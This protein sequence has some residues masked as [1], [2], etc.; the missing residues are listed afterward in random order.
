MNNAL[1]VTFRIS[2]RR[3]RAASQQADLPAYS[4][5]KSLNRPGQ[6]WSHWQGLQVIQHRNLN[7]LKPSFR[8]CAL[9]NTSAL[10]SGFGKAPFS[11]SVSRPERTAPNSYAKTN[12]QNKQGNQKSTKADHPSS[13]RNDLSKPAPSASSNDSLYG[14]KKYPELR[15]KSLPQSSIK[16]IFGPTV[17]EKLGNDILRKLQSQRATGTLDD[18]ARMPKID[19]RL[20]AEGLM[21]LRSKYPFDED[22]AIMKR[23]EL[24]DLQT[25]AQ[26]IASAERLGLY[27][28]NANVQQIQNTEGRGI[29]GHSVLD[30]MHKH[31]EEVAAK[32]KGEAEKKEAQD[33]AEEIRNISQD[34]KNLQSPAGRAVLAR[35]T[36]SAEWVKRYKERAKVS[37]LTEPEKL[38]PFVRLWPSAIFTLIVIGASILFA[39]N[40]IP[41]PRQARLF[42]DTPPAAATVQTLIFINI[43][44][45]MMWKTPPLWRFMNRYCLLI[46]AFPKWESIL[47]NVFSHQVFSHLAVNMLGL[48]FAGTLRELVPYYHTQSLFL[49]TY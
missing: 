41:P 37:D 31:F 13:S 5:L 40:Y 23:I 35:R 43:A 28:P 15:F 19:P 4:P 25:D 24:E 44:A 2:C 6:I 8:S 17:P 22:A 38:H 18:V 20:E 45:F 27:Q 29:Y 34:S 9:E 39:Q 36:E 47:G 33:Q 3:L 48:W 49:T 14:Y 16:R 10:L 30:D 12:N 1:T 42:P 32:K 21:W 26:L 7:S 11:T 46:T